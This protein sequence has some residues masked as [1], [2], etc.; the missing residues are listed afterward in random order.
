MSAIFR[1]LKCKLT[2]DEWAAIAAQLANDGEKREQLEAQKKSEAS[3]IK[4][5]IDDVEKS[6]SSLGVKVRTHE[7]IRAVECFEKAD[8][9]RFVVE[10]YRDDTGELIET[11]PMTSAERHAVINPALPGVTSSK[12]SKGRGTETG[13]E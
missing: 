10:L 5:K 7:E 6:I 8:D 3:A 11:R 4:A 13:A 2:N 1:D 12:G 9:K